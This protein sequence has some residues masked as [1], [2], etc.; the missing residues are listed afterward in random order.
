M[1]LDS[2]AR[3]SAQTFPGDSPV[4]W[5]ESVAHCFPECTLAGARSGEQSWELSP[6]VWI[7]DAG[8]PSRLMP[9]ALGAHFLL[10][11]IEMVFAPPRLEVRT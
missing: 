6:G 1:L 7:W 10:H 8:V 3:N 4:T 2:K 5:P 11:V 9:A